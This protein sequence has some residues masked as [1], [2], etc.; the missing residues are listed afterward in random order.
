MSRVFLFVCFLTQQWGRGRTF[1]AQNPRITGGRLRESSCFPQLERPTAAL[2]FTT[3][4]TERYT[5]LHYRRVWKPVRGLALLSSEQLGAI[6]K[7]SAKK[8][9]EAS[10]LGT[11][12]WMEAVEGISEGRCMCPR[13]SLS[14]L[15]RQKLEPWHERGWLQSRSERIWWQTRGREHMEERVQVVLKFLGQDTRK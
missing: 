3:S 11:F 9:R 4:Q 13:V 1:C 10:N 6:T 2:E 14:R 12:V 5:E 15:R 7:Y 8:C